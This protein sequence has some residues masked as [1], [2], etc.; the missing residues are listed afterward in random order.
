MRV[1]PTLLAWK[2]QEPE[3]EPQPEPEQQQ[4]QEQKQVTLAAQQPAAPWRPGPTRA[5]TRSAL[6]ARPSSPSAIAGQAPTVHRPTTTRL[7]TAEAVV[8]TE[9]GGG[10]SDSRCVRAVGDGI[11]LHAFAYSSPEWSYTCPAALTPEWAAALPEEVWERLRAQREAA[12]P[13]QPQ[14]PEPP[15]D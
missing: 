7:R 12:V 2:P 10:T 8:P 15:P 3:P 4:G 9:E 1:G 6:T 11:C 13:Q 5:S 14:Q